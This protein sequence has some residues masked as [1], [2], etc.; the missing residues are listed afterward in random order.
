MRHSRFELGFTRHRKIATLSDAAFRLWVSA[1]DYAREQ[2]TDGR[3]E[4]SDLDL[5]PCCP[6]RGAKRT[7]VLAELTQAGRFEG[8]GP[9]LVHN[10]LR[11]QDSSD[12]VE[13]KR[14]AA[15][16]RMS[17]VRAN[18]TRTDGEPDANTGQAFARTSSE[19]RDGPSTSPSDLNSD[20]DPTSEPD[21]RPESK[22]AR[23]RRKPSTALPDP[24]PPGIL[25]ELI[26]EN[27]WPEWWA[28]DRFTAFCDKA[29]AGDW[30]YANWKAALRN[31][32]RGEIGYR[33][34]PADLAHLAP[35]KGDQPT[36]EQLAARRA[37]DRMEQAE[38]ERRE[39]LAT[40]GKPERR[41]VQGLLD[42]IGGR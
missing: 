4:H 41:D 39:K 16:E 11:W 40:D 22:R 28:K 19:V 17:R 33:R 38:R 13:R 36:T 35:G 7:A 42:G 9:W 18:G 20:S 31:F 3:V 32:L 2:C 23:G 34:G 25:A 21:P 26:E 10:F 14:A 37:R 1:I 30:R 29:L 5:I 6:K 15:R 12:V 8:N 24:F 27:R